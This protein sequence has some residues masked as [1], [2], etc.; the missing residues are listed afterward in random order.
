MRIFLAEADQQLRLGLQM[1]LHQ[2]AGTYVVGMAVR[3]DKLAVQVEA[4]EA[5]VVLLDWRLPGLSAPRHIA[6]IQALDSPPAII[7]LSVNPDVKAEALAAGAD[8]CI[9]K[10]EPPDSLLEVVGSVRQTE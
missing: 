7:V 10:S 8:A 2:E 3:A 4:S 5:D 9:S 6:E 1:L